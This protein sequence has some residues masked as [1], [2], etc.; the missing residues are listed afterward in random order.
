MKG[1]TGSTRTWI[2]KDLEPTLSKEE[3][4]TAVGETLKGAEY[5]LISIRPAYGHTQR[6]TF[7]VN[8]N[9]AEIL[10]N[11]PQVKIGWVSCRVARL[12]EEVRCYR[13]QEAGHKAARCKGPDRS[14]QCFRC[15]QEG[16]KKIECQ[17]KGGLS[18]EAE[19]VQELAGGAAN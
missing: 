11:L 19:K 8:K 4:G 15:G 9:R 17:V 12:D 13:C 3:I 2:I 7:L 16:H 18:R 1:E 10:K 5:K 6:V 14:K